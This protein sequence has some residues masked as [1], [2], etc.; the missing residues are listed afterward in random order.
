MQ[1]KCLRFIEKVFLG[2]NIWSKKIKYKINY[3]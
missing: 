1:L 3:N 2:T